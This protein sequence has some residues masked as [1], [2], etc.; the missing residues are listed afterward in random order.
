MD[1][2]LERGQCI[3]CCK[4]YKHWDPNSEN[5][6]EN[7]YSDCA[8]S[9]YIQE[10]HGSNYYGGLDKPPENRLVPAGDLYIQGFYG[11]SYDTSIF[12]FMASSR[13]LD[14]L[15]N[16]HSWLN[17]KQLRGNVICDYCIRAMIS[18]NE[19]KCVDSFDQD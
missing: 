7:Q 12:T 5:Q 15:K 11:S 14:S 16:V 17:D 3:R 4:V 1:C 13:T 6:E 8:S 10:D 19:I 9:I 18:Q 2:T